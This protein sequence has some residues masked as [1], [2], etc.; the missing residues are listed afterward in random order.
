[1]Q[2]AHPDARPLLDNLDVTLLEL[3]TEHPRIGVLELSRMVGVTRATVGSRMDKLRASGVVTGYGPQLDVVAAGYPVQA[4]VTLE[5]AQGDLDT[6]AAL[7]QEMPGVLEA[8]STTGTGDV[9]VRLAAASNDDLQQSLLVLGQSEAVRRSTSVVVLA[10]VVSA[11]A[12]PL[13]RRDVPPTRA[14][15]NLR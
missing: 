14:S 12:L 4:M 15:T 2:S 5:I 7:L 11:R 9:V 1:M 13:L 10:T 6:V 3:L 8:Y